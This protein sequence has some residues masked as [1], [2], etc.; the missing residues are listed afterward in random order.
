MTMEPRSFSFDEYFNIIQHLS[1]NRN[2]IDFS[3]VNENSKNFILLRHDVEYSPD[4]ALKLAIFESSIN[5][6]SSYFFQVRNNTYNLLSKRNIEICHKIRELGHSIGLHVHL[7]S[8]TRNVVSQKKVKEL[9]KTDIKIMNAVLGFKV[10]RFSYHRPTREVLN[11]DNNFFN[12][13]NAYNKKYFTLCEDINKIQKHQPK[14][15]SDSNHNWKSM[16]PF[17]KSIDVYD[18]LQLLTHPFSWTKEGYNNLENFDFLIKEKKKELVMSV[19]SEIKT[20]P[21]SLKEFQ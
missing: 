11:F 10:D 6:S 18:K 15:I 19:D 1:K 21:E 4:R 8:I 17:E 13:Y 14:Y 5:V 7:D 3:Q 2:I 12:L 20:F 16:H 9:I